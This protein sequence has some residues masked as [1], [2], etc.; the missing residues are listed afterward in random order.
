MLKNYFR[1]AWRNLMKNKIFSFINC[2]G[3][4]IGL[5]CCMLIVLY[6]YHQLSYDTYHSNIKRLYQ[7]G[8][9]FVTDGKEDRFP[10]SPAITAQNMQKDFPEIEQTARMLTFSF[11]GE[12]NTLLQYFPSD[13]NVISFYEPGGAAADNSF[14]QLFTYHFREGDMATALTKPNSVVISTAIAR[15][16]FGRQP[17]FHK[18]IHIS[19]SI[20]G[21]HDCLVTGV[22]EPNGMPSHIDAGFII[23]FYG[24]TIE[25][26]MKKDG[27]N[28]AFDNMYTT[29]LLLKPGADAQK[30]EARFPAF[31]DKYAGKDLR[32]AGFGR[33]DF[34]L[35]VKDIHLHADMMEMTPSVS[36]SYLYILGSIAVFILLLACINFMNLSTARSSR[37]SSEVGIRKVL[38]AGKGALVGQFLGESLLMAAIA[39]VFALFLVRV[40]LPVFERISGQS[41][42]LSPASYVPL[43]AFFFLLSVV[44]GLLAG[45]YPA[46]YLSSFRP[47]KVLKGRFSSSWAAVSLRKGLVV[48][49]FAISVILIVVTVVISDQ[50]HFLRSADLGFSKDRQI[51]IPLQSQTAKD[52]YASFRDELSGNR[53]VVSVGASAYYPGITNASDDNF[54]REGQSVSAGQRVRINHI[55]EHFLQTL[56]IKAVAGR[57]FSYDHIATDT[58]RHVIINEEAVRRIGFVSPQDALGK[59]MLSSY[60]GV[61]HAD[62]I[63]GVVKDFHYEDLHSPILPYM[64]YLNDKSHYNYA[65]V[66]VATGNM[67]IILRSLEKTW[68]QLN[69]GEPFIYSFMEEDFQRNYASDQ[70]LSSIVHYF[71]VIAIVISCLGLFGLSLFSAEQRTKEISVRKVLGARVPALVLLLSKDFLQL[72]VFAVIVASPIAWWAMNKWLQGFTDRIHIG[73]SVFAFT[74]FVVT[75]IAFATISFQVFRAAITNPAKNL[76]NE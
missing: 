49:Q 13:G 31:I 60:K 23:S 37:R 41:N 15:K 8:G 58:I 69:P 11:F 9:I 32:Q 42:L 50:M 27:T 76:K 33:K 65:I 44:T 21:V 18:V 2:I 1:M 7:V 36:V 56:G 43:L 70:R 12:Y 10:C 17:A 46:F 20:N 47:V 25:D 16:I 59:K 72:V 29:Y 73:L 53:D 19:S 5:T 3:L 71:T 67:D 34:L 4:S 54:H 61:D 6:L 57:L 39:F 51:V 26:R 40:L 68:H 52:L 24:G 64:F 66:H 38:G 22:Y 28:M 55:D 48:F 14:F 74:A 30:L 35:P 45:S 63:V 62:E 75:A